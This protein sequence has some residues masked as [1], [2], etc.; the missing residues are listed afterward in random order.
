MKNLKWI[1]SLVV[2]V[3]LIQAC[4]KVYPGQQI[5][6]NKTSKIQAVE[7][8]QLYPAKNPLPIEGS[9]M[10]T[11]QTQLNLS[12]KIGGI[13]DRVYFKEGQYVKKGQ[14]MA[15][16]KTTEIDA[17]VIKANQ[18]V[19]KA[20]RDL[21]RVKK[22]YEESAAT[23]EQVQDLT[24]VLELAEADLEI[25]QFNQSYAKIIAPTSG[26]ILLKTTEANELVN[27]GTPI[28]EIAADSK[29]AYV[30]SLGVADKDVIKLRLRDVAEVSLDAFPGMLIPAYVS[31]IAEQA[32]PR[33]GVFNIELTLEQN[34]KLTLK[35][36]FIGKVKIYPSKQAE[37]FPVPMEALVEGSEKKVHVFLP[38]ES[39]DKAYKKVLQPG[40]IGD[41]FFT[42]TTD[43][44]ESGSWIITAGASYLNDGDSISVIN[45]QTLSQT[46][47]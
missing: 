2:L 35:N 19:D 29:E 37:Y 12:F 31:E 3:A 17:Q 27:P 21:E 22:L 11:S 42:V 32:D 34:S 39:F 1:V 47:K 38:N 7:I 14:L 46:Q 13:V 45:K 10:V 16:L 36:G 28:Y 24:T 43:Q 20:K 15:K 41:T 44:L 26:R 4:K 5:E 9:G 30:L 40:M 23:L 8:E 6:D 33:T 18:G 25:A